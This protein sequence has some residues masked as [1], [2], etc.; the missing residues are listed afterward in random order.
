MKALSAASPQGSDAP[1]RT[2]IASAMNCTEQTVTKARQLLRLNRWLTFCQR[3]R[4]DKGRIIGDIYLMHEE[5]WPL[6]ETMIIDTEYVLFVEDIAKSETT[7]YPKDARKLARDILTEIQEFSTHEP[8]QQNFLGGIK[9]RL[10]SRINQERSHLSK[11]FDQAI[12]P[13]FGS[14]P[15]K[16]GTDD[17]S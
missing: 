10:V 13:D 9:G 14:A 16:T 1:R 15:I 3:V 6:W 2:D 12:E 8:Q 11:N 5:P 4:D 17:D 7:R